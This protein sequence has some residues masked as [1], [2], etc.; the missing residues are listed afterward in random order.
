M[1]FDIESTFASCYGAECPYFLGGDDLSGKEEDQCR[2]V[3]AETYD[4]TAKVMAL[5]EED[6]EE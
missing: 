1:F 4:V 3:W 2:K 5:I 6:E